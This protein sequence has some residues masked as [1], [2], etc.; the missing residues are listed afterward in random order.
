MK[1]NI[2][3]DYP[4]ITAG[5]EWKTH[6][7]YTHDTEAIIYAV[8]AGGSLG[9]S[10]YVKGKFVASNLCLVLTCKNESDYPI[11]LQ[12][13]N[14]YFTSIRKKI[15]SDL[16]DGTSKLT[17]SQEM[18]ES[19][20]IDYVP[21]EEQKNFVQTKLQ[22]FLNIQAEYEKAKEHLNREISNLSAM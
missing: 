14:C 3:G 19:Y 2:E 20:Y 6:Y 15:V 13:Y 22:N 8:S 4:F 10:H 16:A 1:K 5:E 17:I 11:D 9:R 12:F 21:Y 18:F 7:E